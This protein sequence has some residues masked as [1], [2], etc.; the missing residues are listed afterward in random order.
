MGKG[1]ELV[2][3]FFTRILGCMGNFQA[4]CSLPFWNETGCN[5]VFLRL[6]LLRCLFSI[7][8][9]E[10]MPKCLHI[11]V[12]VSF[13]LYRSIGKF[14]VVDLYSL[15]LAQFALGVGIDI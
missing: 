10:S 2:S 4:I 1:I 14:T 6:C 15:F 12:P 8:M 5:M 11:S 9:P 13:L 3:G 7:R